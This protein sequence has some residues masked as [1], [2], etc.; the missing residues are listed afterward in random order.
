MNVK[1]IRPLNLTEGNEQNIITD[2]NF[3]LSRKEEWVLV[4][5]PA[6]GEED[7]NNFGIKDEIKYVVCN[8][9]ETV[10]IN[11]RPSQSLLHEFYA[12][13]KSYAYWNKYIYPKT[14]DIRREKIF[15]PR[16]E[17]LA[18]YL[19]KYNGS[20]NGVFLEVGAG[21]GTFCQELT[22]LKQFKRIVA[23]EPFPEFAEACRNKG[24]EVIQLPIEKINEIEIADVI[25]SFEVIEHLFNPVS[26]LKNCYRLLKPGGLLYLSCPNVKGF[27][28]SMLGL[29]STTFGEGHYNYYHPESLSLLF[30]SQGFEVIE[31]A[32]PGKLDCG[33]V[34]DHILN[35][36]VDIKNQPFLQEVLINRWEEL[37]QPFQTFL[38][39]NK[40]SSHMVILA[41]KIPPL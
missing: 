11:P 8:R 40:L 16:V 2:R 14:E 37:G 25:A 3:L 38:A 26:F 24:I 17:L 5:C 19:K 36:T 32:T 29:L 1:D 27:D 21:F 9:C 7:T 10:Y 30:K 15:R 34:R 18:E 12:T 33:I 35:G 22:K 20:I 6:C 28:V 23:I 31:I 13:S 39:D 4:S 41:R